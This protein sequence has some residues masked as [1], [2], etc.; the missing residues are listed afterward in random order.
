MIERGI[1]REQQRVAPQLA[2]NLGKC[3]SC[4]LAER[5]AVVQLKK[6]EVTA[7]DD[8]QAAVES[9]DMGRDEVLP[10][11][12]DQFNDPTRNMVWATNLQKIQ[13][14]ELDEQKRQAVVK[15]KRQAELA[16]KQADESRHT[17]ARQQLQAQREDSLRQ[18]KVAQQ[19]VAANSK[20]VHRPRA[21]R[22]EY[23]GSSVGDT[24]AEMLALLVEPIG[25]RAVRQAMRS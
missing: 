22:K 4:P 6:P 23:S 20:L 1:N 24:V 2:I 19:K 9:V 5:C 3:A 13:K 18:Q 25:K 14:T 8:C 10:S 11:T 7:R 12:K 17:K 16:R 15:Q 21:A